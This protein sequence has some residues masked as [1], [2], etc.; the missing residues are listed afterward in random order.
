VGFLEGYSKDGYRIKFRA[1]GWATYSRKLKANPVS[2]PSFG[3]F[4]TKPGVIYWDD[5]KD[6]FLC[7]K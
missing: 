7:G 4:N 5:V 3:D 1:T 2:P 6:W